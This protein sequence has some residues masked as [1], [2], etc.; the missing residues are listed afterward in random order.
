MGC[1]WFANHAHSP[2]F[3]LP[4]KPVLVRVPGMPFK[5]GVTKTMRTGVNFN[6]F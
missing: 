6:F 1:A 3:L 4:C 2:F 5:S